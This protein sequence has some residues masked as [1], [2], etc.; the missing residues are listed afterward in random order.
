MENK[1]EELIIVKQLPIIEEKLKGLSKEIDDKVKNALAL[2][3]SDE[4]VKEVKKVRADL[5]ADFKEL[6]AQRKMVKEKVLAP[7]QAFEEVYKT[8][9]SDKFINAD[10]ELKMKIQ[11]VEQEQK[12]KKTVELLEYYVEYG[13]SQNLDWLFE[14][15][16]YFDYSN[17]NVTL[18]ASMKSLKEQVKSFVDKIVDDMQL[19][20]T[21]EH[22]QEIFVEY[23]KTLNVSKAITEVSDRYKQLEVIKD[24][25]GITLNIYDTN[26]AVD[27]MST[28]FFISITLEYCNHIVII[29]SFF[30]KIFTFIYC[31]KRSNLN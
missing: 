16:D 6:E 22:R 29:F 21:Q 31:S 20:A 17:I 28:A 23:K 11:E 14:D 15:K 2:V 3:C 1:K 8:Y 26:K 30:L 27:L 25:L 4:T 13:K 12:N 7:Y 5:N 10:T 19:M 24:K 18:S 9:V